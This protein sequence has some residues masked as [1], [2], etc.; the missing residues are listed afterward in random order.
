MDWKKSVFFL[1]PFL[2]L[3]F[4]AVSEDSP[5]QQVTER[6]KN[7][8]DCQVVIHDSLT[9]FVLAPAWMS[10]KT[11]VVPDLVGDDYVKR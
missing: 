5:R 10:R 11:G 4:D 9:C 8:K 2:F 3:S 1:F 7:E 6:K